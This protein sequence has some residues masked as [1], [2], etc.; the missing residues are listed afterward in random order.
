MT[1]RTPRPQVF[2][3]EGEGY[4]E[5][6]GQT[7]DL[8]SSKREKYENENIGRIQRVVDTIRGLHP[9]QLEKRL[10]AIKDEHHES[11]TVLNEAYDAL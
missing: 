4:R 8:L 3:T 10:Q 5:E 1:E 9:D 6:Y 7:E 2:E 11:A